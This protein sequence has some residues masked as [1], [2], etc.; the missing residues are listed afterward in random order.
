[1]KTNEVWQN[2][3]WGAHFF[4]TNTYRS[5]IGNPASYSMG[6]GWQFLHT[7][8]KEKTVC[9]LNQQNHLHKA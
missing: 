3:N 2:R 8:N 7:A 5:A 1:M 9:T 6:T 4:N